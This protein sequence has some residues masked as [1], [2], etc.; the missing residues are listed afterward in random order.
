LLI[1]EGLCAPSIAAM[2]RPGARSFVDH[3]IRKTRGEKISS[4][5]P[6]KTITT[7]LKPNTRGIDH[8]FAATKFHNNDGHLDILYT[9]EK[10]RI[11]KKEETS[12]AT[13]TLT[14][15]KNPTQAK[16][17]KKVKQ[18]QNQSVPTKIPR[19][20][21]TPAPNRSTHSPSSRPTPLPTA[22]ITSSP[23]PGPITTPST[24][25][26]STSPAIITLSSFKLEIL[27][28][29]DNTLT[30]DLFFQA[31]LM[32][33]ENVYRDIFS[34]KVGLRR[35]QFDPTCEEQSTSSGVSKYDC[36]FEE[37]TAWVNS[38]GSIPTSEALDA[39]TSQA[40]DEKVF[41]YVAAL[42][43][44]E[45]SEL[46]LIASVKF[47]NGQEEQGQTEGLIAEAAA[48][49]DDPTMSSGMYM[50]LAAFC[51]IAAG[52]IIA[53]VFNM[54]RRRTLAEEH[55]EVFIDVSD[56]SHLC[57]V[58]DISYSVMSKNIVSR[59]VRNMV[60]AT[61]LDATIVEQ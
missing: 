56:D 59:S 3:R 14:P 48:E 42:H 60:P 32:Y 51:A 25:S 41:Q 54:T 27:V 18:T 8:T 30:E 57:D 50:F 37:G 19:S 43:K 46:K 7:R 45:G 11:L 49:N 39:I 5:N 13:P 61:I 53:F 33:L 1:L 26:P 28:T 9:N 2:E 15:S 55:P 16:A 17:Q 47:L 38:A 4:L 31:T 24:L 12:L 23:T 35:I 20:R 52:G 34:E 40:F 21:P 22:V 10:E 29:G 58:S 6:Y 44:S 36:T